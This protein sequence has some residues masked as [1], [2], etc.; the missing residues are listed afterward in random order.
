VTDAENSRLKSGQGAEPREPPAIRERPDREHE[1]P[2]E[3]FVSFYKTVPLNLTGKTVNKTQGEIVA[4]EIVRNAILKGRPRCRCWA[5]S[6]RL[7]KRA[8][9]REALKAK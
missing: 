5:S 2:A 1:R 6:L 8:K 4:L 9:W 3:G 7:T